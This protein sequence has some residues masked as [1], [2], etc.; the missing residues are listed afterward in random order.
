[1][2]D[3]LIDLQLEDA[4]LII[5]KGILGD[6]CGSCNQVINNGQQTNSQQSYTINVPSNSSNLKVNDENSRHRLRKIQDNSYK[7]G[8]GSYSRVLSNANPSTLNDELQLKSNQS[9]HYIN[10]SVHLPDITNSSISYRKGMGD[11]PN[12]RRKEW[13]VNRDENKDLSLGNG[14]TEE[15]DKTIVKADN[16]IKASIK[17]YDNIEKKK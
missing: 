17:Y 10:T 4:P 12:M 11:T 13:S 3:T 7:Y 15:L 1:L 9:K 8:T 5:K 6:K 14:L 16:L 2:V